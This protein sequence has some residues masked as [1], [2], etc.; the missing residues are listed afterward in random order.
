MMAAELYNVVFY[1]EVA[2]GHTQESI[3]S[4]LARIFNRPPEQFE[5]IFTNTPA[6]IKTNAD[7]QTALKFQ[8]AF[9]RAGA[10]CRVE[11]VGGSPGETPSEV[12]PPK[13]MVCPKCGSEQEKAL[14]CAFCGI[15]VKQYVKSHPEKAMEY[16][17]E[18]GAMICPKCGVE[19][20]ETS[21][22]RNCGVFIKNYLR[23][24]EREAQ[25]QEVDAGDDDEYGEEYEAESYS[26][27]SAIG[28]FFSK[29]AARIVGVAIFL[30][31]GGLVGYCTTREESVS[32]KNNDFRLTKPRGWTVESDLNDD[33]D[34]QIANEGKEGYLVVISEPKVDFETF[35]DYKK[36]SAL[37]RSFVE[38]FVLNY[39]EVSGPTE[40]R[41]SL[42][43]GVQYEITGSVDGIRIKYLHTT[44]EGK[45]YFHQII[46][47]SLVSEYDS[48]K[49]AFDKILESF[50]EF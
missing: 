1:G 36:H 13:T 17:G 24:K 7:R 38:E 6:T 15:V 8:A 39:R 43:K 25:Q 2:E 49:A 5:Q 34:I 30:V 32:S 42:M 50:Y 31:I 23:M 29:L 12:Q 28:G 27:P 16:R 4:Q 48:N 11:A 40:I 44:V 10:L 9:K 18:E 33:A 14:E 37:T 22:C 26:E 41:I 45:K 20:E 3:K 21:R 19:Q 46:A 35:V 47:W